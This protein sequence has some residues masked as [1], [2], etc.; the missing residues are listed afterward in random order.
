MSNVVRE[1]TGLLTDTLTVKVTKE[2]YLNTYQKKV[3]DFSKTANIPGFRKGMVPVGMVQKMYGGSIFHDEV[4]KTAEKK[5]FEYLQQERPDIFAQP[6]P[7][8]N[9]IPTLDHKN[10]SDYEF[11]FE[12]G[13]K[14]PFELPDFGTQTLTFH[15]VAVTPEMLEEELNRMQI[16]GGKMTEPEVVDQ[17]ENVLN[18][19]FTESDANGTPIEGGIKKENSVLLKYFSSA[20]QT[21]LKGKK[22]GETIVFQL[23]QS[24]DADKLGMMM[25][26]LGLDQNDA[27][28]AKKHFALELGKIGLVEKR[29]LTEDFFQEVYPG[30][31]FANET[32]F[33]D[34]LK[35]DIEK[36]WEAQSRNQI[37]DQIYHMLLDGVNM[38]FPE[39][40]LKR[41]LMNGTE[42]QKTA[43]EAEREYPVFKN[44]LKW[45]LIS[46]K[47]IIDNKLDVEQ[48]E[49][50]NHMKAEV[51]NYFGQMSLGENNMDWLDSYLDRMMKDEKQ[52][53]ST[54][55]RLVTE[56]LFHFVETKI[57]TMEK[58]VTADELNAMQHHH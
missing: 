26:D 10:P 25:Q 5:L 48:E 44:Q 38:D 24:F 50:R 42:K 29:E 35:L 1:N 33:K 17:D 3:K 28:A 34:A 4:I 32:E 27:D 20:L 7:A 40:F 21:K 12:I 14:A 9:Q 13:L 52:V 18:V 6:L 30:K 15:K 54:Y 36:Y 58:I 49:L 23:D 43:E 41:W 51:M 57:S 11:K 16:K 56:K 55:R 31:T 45:T 19:I 53:E 8:D 22:L 2:D 37:H 46:D 47:I 39:A